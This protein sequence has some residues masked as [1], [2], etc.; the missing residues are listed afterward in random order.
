MALHEHIREIIESMDAYDSNR[1]RDLSRRLTDESTLTQDTDVI[2]LALIAYSLNKIMSKD[3]FREKTSGLF[4][5]TKKKLDRMDFDGVLK[6]IEDFDRRHGFFHGTLV[7]KARTKIGSR[8]YSQGISLSQSSE[9]TGAD[10]S[11]IQEYAAGTKT[12]E[13]VG[14]RSLKERVELAR[15]LFQ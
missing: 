14:G 9:L 11:N 1:S 15:K 6:N 2:N 7:D 8:M 5:E 10:V 12:H 13:E 3:H 4:S